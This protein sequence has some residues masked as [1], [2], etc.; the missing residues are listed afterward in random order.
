MES[1]GNTYKKD[2]LEL[3]KLVGKGSYGEVHQAKDKKY[4]RIVAVKI[5][6][7][8]ENWLPLLQEINMVI[9]MYNETIVNY[10]GWFFDGPNMWIIMEYCDGGSLSDIMRVC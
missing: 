6:K 9:D 4:G 1:K 7:L 5:L 10:Y 8:D 2:D 3:I